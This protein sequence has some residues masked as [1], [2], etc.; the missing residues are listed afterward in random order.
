[1]QESTTA[2]RAVGVE[3]TEQEGMKVATKCRER[4]VVDGDA[5]VMEIESGDASHESAKMMVLL[6]K[7]R[8]MTAR[9][10]VLH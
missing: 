5:H 10:G 3:A 6:W 9:D 7:R 8:T 4:E 1:M 2:T